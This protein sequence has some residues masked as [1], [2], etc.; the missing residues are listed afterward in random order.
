MTIYLTVAVE[1]ILS[2]EA[3]K[4][5]VDRTGRYEITLSLGRK[6]FG[7]L[8][9]N[10][11]SFNRSAIGAPFLLLTDQDTPDDC[12]PNKIR[13][14]LGERV[15]KHHNFLFRVAV[16]EIEAWLL[17]DREQITEFLSVPLNRVPDSVDEIADPKG[18]LV[19]LARASRSNAIKRALVP[20]QGSTVK[21]GPNYNPLLVQFIRDIWAPGTAQNHSTSLRRMIDRLTAFEPLPPT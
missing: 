1:D 13:S 20:V 17:A 11:P 16:M 18:F 9:S 12:P 5:I 3:I 2:D 4:K 19:N 10:A 21:V 8:K 14:W 15:P 7:Y 6:G